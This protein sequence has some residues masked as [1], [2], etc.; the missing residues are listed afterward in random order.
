MAHEMARRETLLITGARIIVGDGKVIESGA[1]L[2]RNGKIEAVYDGAYPDA[3]SLNADV[4]EAAGKTI[5]PGLIDV[6]VHLGAPGGFYS[7]PQNY[8]NIEKSMRREL[9]AYLYSGV[10]AVKSTG[11]STDIAL[12]TRALV[13]SGEY[14]GAELFAVGPLFTTDGGH[15]TEYARDMPETLRANFEAQFL[16]RPKTAA[17]A[18]KDV[19]ELKA[20]HVDGIKGVLEA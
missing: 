11:D 3:K 14:L 10:T 15:G 19:D 4:L 7:D 1:V 6:H 5:L 2:L 12:K 17:E 20:Q 9:A 16:R 8:M 18:R 13:N